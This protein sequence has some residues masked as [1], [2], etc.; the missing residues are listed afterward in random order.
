MLKS[1]I[2]AV[3]AILA[4]IYV[5]FLGLGKG[6]FGNHEGPG[7]IV[8]QAVPAPVMRGR[9]AAEAS[10]KRGRGITSPKQI[11]FGDLHV[12]TTFSFDA[13]F[14]SLPML[15][16]EGSH[17][18][19]DA[20]DYARY[21]SAL[22][23]FSLND[24]AEGITPTHWQE[25]IKAIQ[26]CNALAGDPNNPD[27]VA[28][29]GWEWTQVG[30][31]P[32]T[33]YGHKNVILREIDD[34]KIP[35]RPI[36]A[37]SFTNRA[38][39]VPTKTLSWLAAAGRDQRYLDFATYMAERQA[40]EDCPEGVNTKELPANCH[41]AT[42]TPHDLFRKLDEW[43]L[44]ALVIPHGTT[45]GFYTPA[46]SA[47]DK[48]LNAQQHDPN[49][50]TMV[51]IYSGHGNSEQFRDFHEVNFDANHKASCPEP[52]AKYLPS[53][54]RAGEIIRERCRSAGGDEATCEQRAVAA[55]QNYVDAGNAGHLVVPGATPSDWLDAGQCRDCFL[56]SFNFRP[57]SSVQ[58]MMALTNF[59]NP[60]S[61]M[62][63]RFGFMGSSDNHK[64][65]PGTGYKELG[66]HMNTETA[67]A[68][69]EVWRDRLVGKVPAPE[70]QS[71]PFNSATFDKPAFLMVETER[72]ASFFM[73]GGLIATH[74]AGRNREAVWDAFNRR[75]V[76]G[77][78]GDRILLWFDLLNPPGKQVGD[79]LPMGAE[80]TMSTAPIFQVKAIGAFQQ[81]PGCP[82]Y[83][84]AALK[85]SRLE[86]LC[87][88]E[89]YNPSERRKVITRIEVVRVRPQKIPG[90]PVEK[91]ID[92]PWM[93]IP[94]NLDP[95][96]CTATFTDEHFSDG[97]RDA[98]YYVR[99]IE[100]PSSAI[101]GANLRCKYDSEGNC[102]S[103]EPCY[104]D[105]RTET[106]DDCLA[107]VEERAWS[108]PIFVNF[109][110][111]Q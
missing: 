75:E 7:E 47:W 2:V 15:Q 65:R 22:D 8:G 76:Y 103:V 79:P 41:E 16:G 10:A 69:D 68:S 106:N 70:A 82:D 27:L 50:Q 95:A 90:E 61:P 96:G 9:E 26:Q 18:P 84:K 98:L 71:K 80:V 89:C 12:H 25:S 17:P 74:S 58:Y 36:A 33:H 44:P 49:R 92:D 93:T 19:A 46:G 6:W 42:T 66:R 35:T 5:G 23:F 109:G 28:F 104:G 63:F 3:V 73:T 111:P 88:G 60:A 53:C 110:Q 13:F 102:T 86:H 72:Q 31:T 24:H 52:T 83:A 59:D 40:I 67:G 108:S 56:P 97:G 91:L 43:G 101:N 11:L 105:Y 32:E 1:F 39:T 20:C 34:K 100:E 87:G 99:A 85:P 77:T 14:A 4:L 107:S 21:C 81:M 55:R 30:T 45:W 78:S 62:R 64:A 51:E 29:L 48:Q 38:A 54:W 37:R 57:R 94:C